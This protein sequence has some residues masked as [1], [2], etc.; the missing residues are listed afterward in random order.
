MKRI[1][2][3]SINMFRLSKGFC[4]LFVLNKMFIKCPT[5]FS[6]NL[7][8]SFVQVLCYGGQDKLICINLL[9]LKINCRGKKLK[10]KE[11]IATLN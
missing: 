7:L 10:A 5:Q 6:D 4:C 11:I 2:F 1:P 8:A 3:G 9:I